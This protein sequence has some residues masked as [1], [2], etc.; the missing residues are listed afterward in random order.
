MLSNREKRIL[1]IA[2]ASAFLFMA[3]S[4]ALA[5]AFPVP[6]GLSQGPYVDKLVY[7]VIEEDDTRVLAMQAGTIDLDESFFPPTYYDSLDADP[8]IAI[9]SA[10]R[11]GYGHITINCR[12]WPMNETIF[13]QAF[14]YAFDK[15]RVTTDVMNGWSR[16]HDSLVPFPQDRWCIEDELPYHYYTDQSILGN[17]MLNATGIFTQ[18]TDGWRTY[19]GMPIDTIRVE[20]S[21]DSE[22]VAGATARIG[23]DALLALHFHAIAVPAN[24]N[25]YISRLDFHGDYDMVF[26]AYNFQGDDVTGLYKEFRG[27]FADVNYENPCNFRNAT[28]DA[29]GQQFQ[30]G[31]T[32][33]EV[34]NAT[35]WMQL[36]LHEQVPR[37]VVYENTYNQA[38]R[39]DKFTGHVPDSG[40]YIC[41]IWTMRKIH[42]IAGSTGGTIPTGG[43]VNIGLGQEPDSFNIFTTNSAYANAILEEIWPQLYQFGPDLAAYPDLATNILVETHSDNIA[44]PDGHTRFTVDIVQNATWS[45]G[46]PLTAND[47]AFT[48]GYLYESYA[49]G[50]S[51]GSELQDLEN[52]VAVTPFKVQIEFNTESYWH[53]QNFAYVWI[54]PEHIFNEE[55]IGIAGW[56]TW[57]PEFD[58][59]APN[60]NCGAFR[61]NSMEAG[62][63]Y[64]LV[65]NPTFYFGVSHVAPTTTTTPPPGE[66]VDWTLAIVAGA[67]GAAVV[68]LVGG[69]VLLR[70]K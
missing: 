45:D 41:G 69:F 43:T 65:Y 29:L 17:Q 56:N 62:E 11:N 70:Q 23:V 47:I 46:T 13:R 26:Y 3:L 21:S 30:Y 32:F 53:F 42:T 8:N 35:K 57:N 64:E 10:I 68:I 37:L 19:K 36:V 34:Y 58:P 48:I 61:L 44:V 9:F 52:A 25:E 63:F 39:T 66:G 20:Y 5:K 2:F 24:F 18:G 16:E 31:T 67:V 22:A 51:R 7:Q 6:A 54:I 40:N 4:P 50:N 27:D 15:E 60:V 59:A 14:A 49:I 12:D 55:G 28:F 33:E 38:Y 1:A